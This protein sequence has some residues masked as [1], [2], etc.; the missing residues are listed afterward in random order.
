MRAADEDLAVVGDLDL[1][2]RDR[3]ADGAQPVVGDGRG[4]GDRRGL[5]HAVALEHGRA[6]GVEELEDLLGDRRGAGGRLA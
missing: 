5:G 4:G 1:G 3:A 2:A 6:A